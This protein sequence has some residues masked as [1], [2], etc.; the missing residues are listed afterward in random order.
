MFIDIDEAVN[1]TTTSM[2]LEPTTTILPEATTKDDIIADEVKTTVPVFSDQDAMTTVQS[3]TALTS[4]SRPTLTTPKGTSLLPL[5]QS[6]AFPTSYNVPSAG[7]LAGGDSHAEPWITL[8]QVIFFI[9]AAE[10]QRCS[11]SPD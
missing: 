3:Q 7:H 11:K 9:I 8:S 2:P 10:L 6:S 4:S 1:V 5:D